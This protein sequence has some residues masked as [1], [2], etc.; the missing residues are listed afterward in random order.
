MI[1][2]ERRQKDF[3]A[4]ATRGRAPRPVY[5]DSACMSLVPRVVLD[6]LE[7]YYTERGWQNGIV[8]EAKLRELDIEYPAA[9]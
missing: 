5:L 2:G 6:A 9:V 3:P 8:S 7:E 1:N 4:L